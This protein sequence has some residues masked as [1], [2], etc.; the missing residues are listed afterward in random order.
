MGSYSYGDP[1]HPH[2]VTA[3]G[4]HKYTYDANGNQVTRD[5]ASQAWASFNL[6]VLLAQ[7]IGGTT[8]QSQFSYGPDHQ[9][10]K[11]VAS[12]SNGT[13]TTLYVGGLLEK[14]STTSTGKTYWR[15]YVPTPSGMTIVVSR[16]SDGT[17]STTY[18][19]TDHLGSSDSAID[20]SGNV[21]ARESFAAFGARRGGNWSATATPD[22]AGIANTSRRGY[23]GHEHLDNLA[24]IHMNGRV[25]D[26]TAGR[27]LSVDPIIGSLG[28]SQAINPYSYVGNRPLAFT[29]PSGLDG[30]II[31]GIVLKSA[32]SAVFGASVGS[33]FGGQHLPPPPA[34][35]LP[36]QSTQGD[37]G[38][39]GPGPSTPICGG[40]V[41]YAGA[42][43]SGGRGVPSSSWVTSGDSEDVTTP[44]FAGEPGDRAAAAGLILVHDPNIPTAV[45]LAAPIVV[46]VGVGGVL[47]CADTAIFCPLLALAL[48]WYQM[49]TSDVPVPGGSILRKGAASVATSA[50]TI[51]EG[52]RISTYRYTHR[53]ETFIRYES[54]DTA[55]TRITRRGGVTRGTY[56]APASDGLIPVTDRVSV[57]NLP[58]PEIPRPNAVT[59]QPP[60]GTTVVGPRPV[61]GGTGSEVIFPLGYWP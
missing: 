42:S 11:Q 40:W 13:E 32:A 9:R 25:Y 1:A 22:W 36:G 47:L 2:A 8:F 44:S 4:S 45:K 49:T 20:A 56:A 7:P 26:P 33:I 48:D 14:E 50:D 21:I 52:M 35:V 61:S 19:L 37:G 6:P 59:L 23:T 58:S 60:P 17:A 10:W 57:Y 16:N 55:F 3:A 39:C 30:G 34:T 46:A 28:D 29:D 15:H 41:L 24:L 12:Y 31:S 43:A 5:G 27:F 18:L 51:G 53:G 38:T 54:A